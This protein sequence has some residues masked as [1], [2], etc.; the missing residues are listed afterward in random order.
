MSIVLSINIFVNYIYSY[1]NLPKFEPK[2]EF[3]TTNT[4]FD[5]PA[6]RVRTTGLH[7]SRYSRYQVH[8]SYRDYAEQLIPELA[9]H[10]RDIGFQQ[11]VNE[12][13]DQGPAQ[14]FPHTDGDR[15]GRHCIQYL[16]DTGG[17]N[18]VTT[19]YQE[20]GFP[21]YRETKQQFA[22]STLVKVADAVF[23]KNQWT[24]FTTAIVHNVQPIHT[25]RRA[26]SIGFT[27]D[28]LFQQIIEK[29]G[30]DPCF[31]Y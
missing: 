17:P 26:F 31:G 16:F 28:Q 14:L 29:Y 25:S 19:W 10:I 18:V 3:D 6:D 20:P 9:G 8:A 15:R 5:L 11:I 1:L 7:N 13:T 27:N 23:P 12:N 22:S 24:I 4:I 30:T 2:V 21:L